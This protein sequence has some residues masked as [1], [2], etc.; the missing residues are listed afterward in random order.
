MLKYHNDGKEK[1]QSHEVYESDFQDIETGYGETKEQ[2]YLNFQHNVGVYIETL[3]LY[4][5]MNLA[6][7]NLVPVDCSG[8]M[9]KK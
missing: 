2:A 7:E 4:K 9:L 6:I 1:Y 5:E 3:R 8:I